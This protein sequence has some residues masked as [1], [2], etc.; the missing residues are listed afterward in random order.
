MIVSCPNCNQQ[1]ATKLK[2]IVCPRLIS[3]VRSTEIKTFL[4]NAD[5][6]RL[7]RLREA[8]NLAERTEQFT[9]QKLLRSL[10]WAD[11]S[12]GDMLRIALDFAVCNGLLTKI[13][14]GRGRLGHIYT[15][16]TQSAC[17]YWQGSRCI[18]SWKPEDGATFAVDAK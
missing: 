15:N 8:F 9:T 6:T 2:A 12:R 14:F 16:Q 10:G 17:Q 4:K 7:E 1:F 13:R 3:R 11:R 5:R 18:F